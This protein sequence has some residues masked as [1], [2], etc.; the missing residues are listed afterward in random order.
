MKD[1]TSCSTCCSQGEN[2]GD[3]CDSENIQQ[4]FGTYRL[5]ELVHGKKLTISKKINRSAVGWIQAQ[6]WLRNIKIDSN[7][8]AISLYYSY[9]LSK[10]IEK[11]DLEPIRNFN[12]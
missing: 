1:R 8:L 2:L 6:C 9:I 5:K 4:R 3:L 10:N 11:G 7:L 12:F